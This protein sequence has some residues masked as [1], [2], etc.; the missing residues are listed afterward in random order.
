M[1][2]HLCTQTNGKDVW[3]TD[4]NLHGKLYH[5]TLKCVLFTHDVIGDMTDDAAWQNK[6]VNT[7]S[8]MTQKSSPTFQ[9]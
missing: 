1:Y 8:N 2:V 7:N 4:N 3:H 6:E 5:A 9:L